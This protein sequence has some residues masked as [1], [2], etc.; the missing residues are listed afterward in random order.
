MIW[1][2]E[3]V[4]EI[5]VYRRFRV[6]H[7]RLQQFGEPAERIHRFGENRLHEAEKYEHEKEVYNPYGDEY[8]YEILKERFE[9]RAYHPRYR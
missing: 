3:R 7:R 8:E 9:R 5:V 4:R 6:A 1:L 2:R